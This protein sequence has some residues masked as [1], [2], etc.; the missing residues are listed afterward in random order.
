M[1]ELITGSNRTGDAPPHPKHNVTATLDIAGMTTNDGT[2]LTS[3]VQDGKPLPQA[4]LEQLMCISSITPVLFDGPARPIWVGRDH[5]NA[6]IGQWRALI[7]RD[8][9]CIGCG[10]NPN[11]C[12]AHHITYWE[13][14]GQ[15][16]I[17]NLVLV[18]KRCHHN[19]HDRSH[20]L[21]LKNGRWVIRPPGPPPPPAN[22]TRFPTC[23]FPTTPET[24][25][26]TLTA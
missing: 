17:D 4:V 19:I 13:H 12:E 24:P 18:C 11:R 15:T 20:T 21:H 6:T 22:T 5:R 3:L 10:A 7:A 25:H 26:L 16:D 2:P 8:R 14:F 9:G 1:V 23:D